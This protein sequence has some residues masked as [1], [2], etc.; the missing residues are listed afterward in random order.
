MSP[1]ERHIGNILDV[2]SGVLVH[3]CNARGAM[4]R[5]LAKQVRTRYP[6]A[7]A[8][9]RRAYQQFGLEVGEVIW[10]PVRTD[11]G[12]ARLVI[13]NA[14]IQADYGTTRRQVNYGA[15]ERCFKQVA[16][17][18][19]LHGL[20]DVHFPLIGCGLAGGEWNLVEPIIERTLE[21][22]GKHLWVLKMS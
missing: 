1:I 14:V 6:Q 13:A 4:G 5:G 9:Y 10:Y 21:G 3:G 22:L 11:R 12:E 17:I 15:L 8:A 19:R 20:S 18:A 7:Y 16:R 2:T